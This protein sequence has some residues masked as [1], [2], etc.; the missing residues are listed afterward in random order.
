MS[1]ATPHVA[2]GYR[3]L[4]DAGRLALQFALIHC[5]ESDPSVN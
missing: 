3:M 4:D 2:A 1:R 5:G